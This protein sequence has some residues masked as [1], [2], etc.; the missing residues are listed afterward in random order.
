MKIRSSS[1]SLREQY[2]AVLSATGCDKL[3]ARD[4]INKGVAAYKN[5]RYE[6]ATDHFKRAVELDHSL[7]NASS[8]WLR[9]TPRIHSGGGIR[10]T[11][12]RMQIMQS[13]ST[14]PCWTRTLKT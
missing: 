6:Q 12:C 11:T 1:Q 10:P 4:Q 9:P 8:I 14:K 3:K 13:N 2:F 7:Q 5:A